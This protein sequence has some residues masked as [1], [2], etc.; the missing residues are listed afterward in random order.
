MTT[1]SKLVLF[2]LLVFELRGGGVVTGGGGVDD[3]L[4]HG[5]VDSLTDRLENSLRGLIMSFGCRKRDYAA[6]FCT[7]EVNEYQEQVSE[8]GQNFRY[9]TR[10]FT[11]CITVK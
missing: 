7:H 5:Q 9:N 10:S 4:V 11:C 1:F 8:R 6:S 3:G 2:F